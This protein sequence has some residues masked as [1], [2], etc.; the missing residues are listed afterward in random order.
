MNQSRTESILERTV[1]LIT[2][3]LISWATY[4]FYILPNVDDFS[5]FKVTLI[6]TVI[7]F[8][9]GYFWRRFFNKRLHIAIHKF[10]TTVRN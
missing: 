9:R 6:F 1:D 3:F 8:F 5:S 2:A 4:E 7:S 10:L